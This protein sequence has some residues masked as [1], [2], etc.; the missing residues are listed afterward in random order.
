DYENEHFRSKFAV[1]RERLLSGGAVV[2]AIPVVGEL[3][4]AGTAHLD[5]VAG[6][7]PHPGREVAVA[8]A[9]E[10]PKPVLRAA[11]A[12]RDSCAGRRVMLRPVAVP[13]APHL[14]DAPLGN[15]GAELR[16]VM[17]DRDLREVLSPPAGVP[18]AAGAGGGP[19]VDEKRPAAHSAAPHR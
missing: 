5:R 11:E 4:Q 17:H 18:E 7:E 14:V 12:G 2:G 1:R 10:C 15:P 3:P 6:M 16:L 8:A 13:P 19:A 9:E